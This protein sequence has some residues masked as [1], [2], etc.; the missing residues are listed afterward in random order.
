MALT[1]EEEMLISIIEFNQ[2]KIEELLISRSQ[3]YEVQNKLLLL[4]PAAVSHASKSKSNNSVSDSECVEK[5]VSLTEKIVPKI[6]TSFFNDPTSNENVDVT[7]EKEGD[8]QP[9]GQDGMKSG[10]NVIVDHSIPLPDLIETSESSAQSLGK[11]RNQEDKKLGTASVEFSEAEIEP[12][13]IS[14]D[15]PGLGLDSSSPK[16]ADPDRILMKNSNQ[17]A[18]STAEPE[19]RKGYVWIINKNGKRRKKARSSSPF[20][21]LRNKNQPPSK[22]K[23]CNSSSTVPDSSSVGDVKPNVSFDFK[24]VAMD[25]H[26]MKRKIEIV[27]DNEPESSTNA[28][29]NFSDNSTDKSSLA[30]PKKDIELP[31]IFNSA[32][33]SKR[34]TKILNSPMKRKRQSSPKPQRKPALKL[35]PSSSNVL[36]PYVACWAHCPAM[37]AR[38]PSAHCV[39]KHQFMEHLREYH[40]PPRSINLRNQQIVCICHACETVVPYS[41]KSKT[42][43]LNQRCTKWHQQFFLFV[44]NAQDNFAI[45]RFNA[46]VVK[47]PGLAGMFKSIAHHP[48]LDTLTWKNV[49]N[50]H[51][52]Y[53]FCRFCNVFVEDTMRAVS[54]HKSTAL[55]RV[56]VRKSTN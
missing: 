2:R 35:N 42:D 33:T 40:T 23:R 46:P 16:P 56:N 37:S 7:A 24:S 8:C 1:A 47:S 43:H 4:N 14:I 49:K 12:S 28:T 25:C 11:E 52:C 22:R 6:L 44:E 32:I 29:D 38:V 31:P 39:P 17:L 13:T 45:P 3:A 54:D 5:P 15:I 27:I 10:S 34:K 55:H 18:L 36:E 30:P 53:H 9:S 21:E 41:F 50:E 51:F 48:H 20:N 26:E 19:K